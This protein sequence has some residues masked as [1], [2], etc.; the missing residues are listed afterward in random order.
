MAG[1]PRVRWAQAA[2][3]ACRRMQSEG[4]VRSGM[5]ILGA[6]CW[7]SRRGSSAIPAGPIPRLTP[8]RPRRQQRET[9]D[10]V[11]CFDQV[12]SRAGLLP[13]GSL[14]RLASC[15]TLVAGRRLQM[16]KQWRTALAPVSVPG[17]LAG[18]QGQGSHREVPTR[19]HGPQRTTGEQHQQPQNVRLSRVRSG[20]LPAGPAQPNRRL[21][22]WRL[23]Y[24]IP[25][26][27]VL[28]PGPHV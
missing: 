22:G 26:P 23:A 10:P 13:Q 15:W 25:R 20:G 24:L 12:T 27:P 1:W 2:T 8:R 5:E 19:L 7:C 18:E 14:L 16:Q 9:L 17:C 11:R 21:P 6:G 3:V 28:L 4:S